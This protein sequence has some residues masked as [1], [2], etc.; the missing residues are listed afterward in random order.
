MTLDYSDGWPPVDNLAAQADFRN[1]GLTA[2]FLAGRIGD[3]AVG[4]ADARFADFK[5]GELE[6]HITA[7]GDASDALKF[8]RAT[9]LE[10]SA[11]HAFSGVEAK[12]SL[13]SKINLFLP[14]K[15]FAHRRVLVHGVFDGVTLNR[16]RI[17]GL[18]HRCE[19]G[20]STSTGARWLAPRFAAGCWE[21]RFK[22]RR[23]RRATA[24]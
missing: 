7:G 10:I 13:L 3:I 16:P 5:T 11:E 2:H 19:R 22:C 24:L 9:P 23:E 8:L 20:F 14:F 6:I 15:D 18:G 12:G 21:D 1:E 17:H 4:S